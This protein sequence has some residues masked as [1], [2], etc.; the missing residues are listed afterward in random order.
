MQAAD[1]ARKVAK[2]LLETGESVPVTP[3]P[4]MHAD[5]I[6]LRG[7]PV[8]GGSRG[9]IWQTDPVAA[10]LAKEAGERRNGTSR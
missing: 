8:V 1:D 3:G 6:R 9:A 5:P 10:L 2:I 7:I 4:G